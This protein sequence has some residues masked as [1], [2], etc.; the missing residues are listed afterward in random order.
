M[1]RSLWLMCHSQES[2][3]SSNLG[4]AEQ[5]AGRGLVMSFQEKL[6]S[7]SLGAEELIVEPRLAIDFLWKLTTGMLNLDL[8]AELE[9]G[10]R[11]VM[12]LP[13]KQTNLSPGAE[14]PGVEPRLVIDF[15]WKLMTGLLNLDLVAEQAVGRRLVMNFRVK[16]M[17][18]SLDA[19][20]PGV[21]PGLV[22]ESL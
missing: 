7:L 20:E 14:E 22:I 10:Q 18:L 3:S 5:G 12:K 6:M 9:A 15:Q 17:T 4:F 1:I 13:E 2:L 8:V 11:L 19:E 21:E 16:S